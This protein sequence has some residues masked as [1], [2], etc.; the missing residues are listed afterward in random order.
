RFEF[1]P[2]KV[3]AD[4]ITVRC[5]FGKGEPLAVPLHKILLVKAHETALSAGQEFFAG[6]QAALRC[7]VHGVKSV[8]E[9]VPLPGAAVS[10]RLRDARGKVSPVANAKAGG[11][12]VAAVQSRVPAVPP[13]SYKMKIVT[14]SPLGEEKLERD[15][16]VKTAPKVLLVPD[17][18]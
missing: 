18:P 9:T 8:S 3:A 1:T 13:G 2:P 11:D 10:V 12:G 14:K 15:V 7:N 6:S 16:K 17:K 5:R 4:K